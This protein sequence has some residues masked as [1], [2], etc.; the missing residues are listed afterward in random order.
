[1]PK[2]KYIVAL[3]KSEREILKNIIKK[4]QSQAKVISRAY[5]LLMA[6]NHCKTDKEISEI[7]Q[8]NK[9]TVLNI[10]KRYIKEGIE[11][12]LYD[13]PRPGQPF[14]L[15]P[16]D[17]ALII[18]LACTDPPKGYNRWTL[19]LLVKHVNIKIKENQHDKQTKKKCEVK[20]T[21]L[22]NILLRNQL[23]PW[24]EKN[25]VCSKD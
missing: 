8:I 16:K 3:E 12:A 15:A 21:H 10:R 2:I 9:D 13:A 23:K 14:K 18:A 24:R 25:V 20:R 17:E 6:D 5:T 1:M 19:N 11:R 4:G 22:Y 7:L